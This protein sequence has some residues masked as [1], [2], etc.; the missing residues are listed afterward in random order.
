MLDGGGD[1][2]KDDEES[3]LVIRSPMHAELVE[4]SKE[5]ELEAGAGDVSGDVGKQGPIEPIAS[6]ED[7]TKD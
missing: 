1:E 2:S 6:Q 3:V 4:G 7:I 5:A